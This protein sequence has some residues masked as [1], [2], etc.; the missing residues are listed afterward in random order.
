MPADARAG[1]RPF[2]AI[3]LAAQRDG[4]LD[5]MAAE[6][7]VSHKCLMPIVGRPLLEYVIEALVA[8]PGLERIRICIEPGAVAAVRTVRGASGEL[9]VPVDYVASAPTITESAYASAEGVRGPMILTTADN[10]NLTPHAVQRMLDALAGGA[11]VALAMAT[12]EAVLAAH[13]QGQR[14]FYEFRDAGYAN[15]NLYAFAGPEAL[16]VAETFREGG[17]FAKNR[18]RLIRV[19]GRFNILLFVLRLASLEFS[20]KKLSRRFGARLTAVVLEDGAH[21]IDVDNP[22]TFGAAETILLAKKA[23]TG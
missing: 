11:D 21:A 5:P 2:T 4:K 14:R 23:R 9:G 16:K 10:V 12:R 7:G 18:K 22:R 20:M 17:Q 19:I 1:G 13:P 15:C 3:I 6:A 8:V